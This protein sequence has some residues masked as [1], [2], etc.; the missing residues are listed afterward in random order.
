[1]PFN[2][3]NEYIQEK[4][5][6]SSSGAWL[7]IAKFIPPDESE[8]LRLVFNTEDIEYAGYNWMGIPIKADSIA[9]TREGEL[10]ELN[11]TL[12][13]IERHL[14]PLLDANKGGV[15]SDVTIYIINSAYL[16]LDPIMEE[17][18]QVIRTSVDH[19]NRIQF[20][21]GVYDLSSYRSPRHRFIREYCRYEVFKGSLC[22]YDGPETECDRTL[23]RC[24]ELGNQKRF[25][26]F[27]AMGSLGYQK[28]Y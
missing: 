18:F 27:P 16:H 17:N 21:L 8:V 25:G 13:D 6:L 12:V 10:P 26:G 4:N 2:I 15:G 3:S 28:S 22:G 9:V 19:M 7:T 23:T 11:M 20:T 14:L 5:K 24:K 1:M